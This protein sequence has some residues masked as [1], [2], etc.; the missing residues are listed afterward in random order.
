V[1]V[2]NITILPTIH[3]SY[4]M[5]ATL[6]YKKMPT[7]HSVISSRPVTCFVS[8]GQNPLFSEV[9]LHYLK[10]LINHKNTSASICGFWVVISYA[11][12][13]NKNI[14]IIFGTKQI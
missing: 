11:A 10:G 3:I 9:P 2:S 13:E 4:W 7:E 6:P 8:N 1:K 5:I 14:Q 12:E